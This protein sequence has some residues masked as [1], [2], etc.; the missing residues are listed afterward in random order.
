M[1]L[2]RRFQ[3]ELDDEDIERHMRLL[4]IKFPNMHGLQATVLGTCVRNVSAP[5]FTAVPEGAKFVQPLNIGDHW[6]TVTNVCRQKRQRVDSGSMH[7]LAA[8][9]RVT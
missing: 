3:A 9:T 1:T 5:M 8:Q 4:R 2:H 7:Q 6:I